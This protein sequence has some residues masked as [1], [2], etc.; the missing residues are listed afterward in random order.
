LEDNY[1]A[2]H[3]KPTANDQTDSEKKNPQK[4]LQKMTLPP[5]LAEEQHLL[6]C[7]HPDEQPDYQGDEK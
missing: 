2:T 3:A 4:Q 1:L 7:L 6:K 5:S